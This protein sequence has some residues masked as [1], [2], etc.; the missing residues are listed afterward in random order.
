[1]NKNGKDGN[2]SKREPTRLYLENE[3]RN[4]KHMGIES[5]KL[6]GESLGNG[7]RKIKQASLMK[8]IRGIHIRT[9]TRWGKELEKA[10]NR[11]DDDETLKL[12]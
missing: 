3:S 4:K 10:F 2:G 9:V 6:C 7:R 5:R 8:E 12:S 11:A 1:M